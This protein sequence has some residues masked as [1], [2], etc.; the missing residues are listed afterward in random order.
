[1]TFLLSVFEFVLFSLLV[2]TGVYLAVR[3]LEK[4]N[5]Q[6]MWVFSLIVVLLFPVLFGMWNVYFLGSLCAV[7]LLG[8][9]YHRLSGGASL[10]PLTAFFL[11]ASFGMSSWLL[12]LAI[13][14][15]LDEWFGAVPRIS[16]IPAVFEV[17]R[18]VL[19]LCF[20]VAP[21]ALVPFLLWMYQSWR[22]HPSLGRSLTL[23]ETR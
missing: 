12:Q 17:F 6:R 5:P 1:M 18:S 9:H 10:S 3:H 20:Q 7:A 13:N 2:G 14:G 8:S 23:E 21:V 11:M 16:G 4:R 19:Y 15:L 22:F